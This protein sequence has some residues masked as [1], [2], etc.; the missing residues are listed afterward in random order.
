MIQSE[1]IFKCNVSAVYV[2]DCMGMRNIR[3]ENRFVFIFIASKQLKLKWFYENESTR[4]PIDQCS[5]NAVLFYKTRQVFSLAVMMA[6]GEPAPRL[7]FL[8]VEKGPTQSS[9]IP[10]GAGCLML[11]ATLKWK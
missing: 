7:C 9:R 4:Y 8:L 11:A 5:V 10:C 2:Y 3:L 1:P 6:K